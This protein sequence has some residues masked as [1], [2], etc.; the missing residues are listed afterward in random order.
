MVSDASAATQTGL[1]TSALN[2]LK[3]AA[4][5]AELSTE[6]LE[7]ALLTPGARRGS[8]LE[9]MSA[10]TYENLLHGITARYP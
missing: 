7:R 2:L 9:Q 8:L 10:I 6:Q 3:Q 4:S 1:E 5:P